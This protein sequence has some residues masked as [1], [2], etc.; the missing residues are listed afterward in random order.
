MSADAEM[1]PVAWQWREF[2]AEDRTWS[3]WREIPPKDWESVKAW[4]ALEPE[5]RQTRPL[6]SADTIAALI[7]REPPDVDAILRS[8]GV[9]RVV[10]GYRLEPKIDTDLVRRIVRATWSAA[11]DAAQSTEMKLTKEKAM[12]PHQ[13]RVVDEKAE[14]DARREKLTAF[15]AGDI[16][17]TLPAEEQHRLGRQATIMAQYSQILGERIDAF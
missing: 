10:D 16:C 4:V 8:V 6:Y 14:L 13:Q 7:P 9:M 11:I 12:Q 15:L 3:R 2:Y 17:R 5:R 1:V